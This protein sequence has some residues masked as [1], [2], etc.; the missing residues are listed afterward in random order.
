MEIY[1]W[2][3]KK[4]GYSIEKEG[5]NI[6]LFFEAKVPPFGYSTYCIKR[7]KIG[8]KVNSGNEKVNGREY[9]V[10]NDLYKIVFDLSKG[11]TIKA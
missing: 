8:K 10:E 5:E 6:R 1:D 11:G 2:K 4:V 7:K 3:Q 9:T